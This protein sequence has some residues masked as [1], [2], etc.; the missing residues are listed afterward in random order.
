MLRKTK[1]FSALKFSSSLEARDCPGEGVLGHSGEEGRVSFSQLDCGVAV[2]GCTCLSLG[3][4]YQMLFLKC[5][6]YTILNIY[7]FIYMCI[8]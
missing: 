1:Q 8:Y 7:T 2:L 3:C 4:F 6:I 5:Y